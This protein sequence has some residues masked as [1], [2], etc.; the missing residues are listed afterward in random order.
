MTFHGLVYTLANED[1][2]FELAC[3]GPSHE[4]ILAVCGSGARA[5]PL[6]GRGAK[7][8]VIVDANPEQLLVC[9]LRHAALEVLG[10]EDYCRFLGL[11]DGVSPAGRREIFEALQLPADARDSL[12]R[13]LAGAGWRAPCYL[14][15]WERSIRKLSV[16]IR[17]AVGRRFLDIFEGGDNGMALAPEV[18]AEAFA[19]PRWEFAVNL[20]SRSL[21]LKNVFF[22]GALPPLTLASSS[23]AFYDAALRDAFSRGSPAT[24][25]FLNLLFLGRVH[26]G[27]LPPEADPRIY[28]ATKAGLSNCEVV[29]VEADVREALRAAARCGESF[30]F[31]S[32]SDTPSYWDDGAYAR[33]RDSLAAGLAPGGSAVLR[34]YRHRPGHRRPVAMLGEESSGIGE[35]PHYP[36]RTGIYA[37]TILTRAAGAIAARGHTPFLARTRAEAMAR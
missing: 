11:T 10:R 2:G 5:L 30:H 26:E 27:C 25:F 9:K 13:T 1:T 37:L 31:V 21:L 29:Y 33:C 32:L 35:E 34:Y 14:G 23:N 3:L 22:R 28:A 4:R 19:S 12:R 6:A 24:N 36:E 8:L 15:R 20:L 16:L 7:R 17:A 18:L